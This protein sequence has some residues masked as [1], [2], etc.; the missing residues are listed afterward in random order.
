MKKH[1]AITILVCFVFCFMSG[2]GR[3]DEQGKQ[4]LLDVKKGLQ[5][6]WDFTNAE[7]KSYEEQNE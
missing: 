3:L 4:C 7:Y 6:R 1:F 5:S 2:C